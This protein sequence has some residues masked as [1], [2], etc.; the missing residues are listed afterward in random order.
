MQTALHAELNQ[1]AAFFLT[2]VRRF[3]YRGFA[4]YFRHVFHWTRQAMTAAAEQPQGSSV[5]CDSDQRWSVFERI[6]CDFLAY[7]RCKKTLPKNEHNHG[8][9]LMMILRCAWS[10]ESPMALLHNLSLLK[11]RRTFKTPR[12]PMTLALKKKTMVGNWFGATERKF[13]HGYSVKRRAL[14]FTLPIHVDGL[15]VDC[16]WL[17]TCRGQSSPVLTETKRFQLNVVNFMVLTVLFFLRIVTLINILDKQK[18]K[19]RS[20]QYFFDI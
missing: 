14:T 12:Y 19:K 4:S 7:I 17:Y 9:S 16:F 20:L 18:K 15:E 6:S 13:Q 8:L 11:G 1:V 5:D 10:P 2:G 3:L